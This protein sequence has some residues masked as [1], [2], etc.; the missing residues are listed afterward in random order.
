MRTLR[1]LLLVI[2]AA[3][4]AQAQQPATGTPP[5]GSFQ[6]GQF[7]A[8]NLYNFNVNFGVP[9]V[10]MPGRGLSFSY[11]FVY[12]SSV[13]KKV[14]IGATY[15][16]RP[17]TDALGN[18]TWGW[19][20]TDLPTSITYSTRVDTIC[21]TEHPVLHE[22]I[23]W[24]A[25]WYY[26]YVYTDADGTRHPFAVAILRLQP[27]SVSAARNPDSHGPAHRHGHRWKRDFA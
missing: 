17:V 25:T 20:R 1:I 16:W 15:A 4:M 26:N 22:D 5:F 8:V 23:P 10:A 7:D 11:G 24:N 27:H 13:W 18:A 3:G 9:I 19:K 12:D 21:Y 6:N 14:Q 2:F